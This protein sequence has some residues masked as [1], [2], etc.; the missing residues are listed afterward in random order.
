[1]SLRSIPT[2][3]MAGFL[4]SQS[5]DDDAYCDHAKLFETWGSMDQG[6]GTAVLRLGV[7]RNHDLSL[8]PLMLVNGQEPSVPENYR[9]PLKTDREGFF[10]VLEIPV[11]DEGV[12]VKNEVLLKFTDSGGRV[13]AVVLQIIGEG[14]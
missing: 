3:V 7:G 10:G 6:V 5:S 2:L 8:P 1:M 12:K 4:L 14:K 9:G 13:K 11:P